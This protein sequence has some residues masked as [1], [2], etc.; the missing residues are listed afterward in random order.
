MI[1]QIWLQIGLALLIIFLLSVAV[2]RY[3]A[4]IIVDRRTRLDPVFDPVEES[5]QSR[6]RMVS[7]PVVRLP[8]QPPWLL[9]L[10]K[11]FD[12]GHGLAILKLDGTPSELG[13]MWGH[14]SHRNFLCRTWAKNLFRGRT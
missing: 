9:L 1:A 5:R 7:S 10:H 11:F 6:D 8:K 4:D 2:G 12:R 14:Q 3:L 13:P